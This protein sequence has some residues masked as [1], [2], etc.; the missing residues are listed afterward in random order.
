MKR[1]IA[2]DPNLDRSLKVRVNL[3]DSIKCYNEILD[4]KLRK[5]T[6]QKSVNFFPTKSLTIR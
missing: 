1:V 5:T 6:V 2:A 4:L 3:Q